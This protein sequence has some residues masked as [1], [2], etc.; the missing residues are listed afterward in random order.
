MGTGIFDLAAKR[1][2]IGVEYYINNSFFKDSTTPGFSIY[3]N[4]GITRQ[5][6]LGSDVNGFDLRT[7]IRMYTQLLMPKKW[8]EYG[9]IRIDIGKFNVNNNSSNS[10]NYFFGGLCLGVQPIIAKRIAIQVATDLG[11]FTNAPITNALFF[12]DKESSNSIFFSGFGIS[13]KLG[14]AI[15]L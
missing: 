6:I 9:G 10:T 13:G 3:L 11:F 5:H 7:E 2:N 12:Q 14:I 8:N 1:Y 15:Q 4:P